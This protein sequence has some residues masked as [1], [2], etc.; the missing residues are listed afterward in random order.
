MHRILEH[1][2]K[3]GEFS[4]ECCLN[5]YD[6]VP[7]THEEYCEYTDELFKRLKDTAWDFSEPGIEVGVMPFEEDGQKFVFRI[8]RM[9]EWVEQ[10][11]TAEYHRQ[12][13]PHESNN[14]RVA[15]QKWIDDREAKL[16]TLVEKV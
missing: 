2:Q 1:I 12:G 16:Q 7:F 3:V 14:D 13:W 11:M 15:W 6:G 4:P 8:L 5:C 9:G 10:I